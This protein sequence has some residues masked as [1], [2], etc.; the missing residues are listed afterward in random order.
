MIA[1]YLSLIVAPQF[2]DRAI[3]EVGTFSHDGPWPQRDGLLEWPQ[4]PHGAYMEDSM[5]DATDIRSP[6]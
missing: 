4:G 2:E 3:R 5:M 6:Q 1:R